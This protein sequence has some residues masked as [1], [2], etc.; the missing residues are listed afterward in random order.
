MNSQIESTETVEQQIARRAKEASIGGAR[1]FPIDVARN[2]IRRDAEATVETI[3]KYREGRESGQIDL[4]ITARP[5]KI[6]NKTTI[7]DG[8]AYYKVSFDDGTTQL[9]PAHRADDM[10]REI[11]FQA[12]SKHK[13]HDN[14]VS[15]WFWVIG[16]LLA[17][18]VFIFIMSNMTTGS[19]AKQG[20]TPSIPLVIFTIAAIIA[21]VIVKRR[22]K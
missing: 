10:K 22:D 13:E 9:C 19:A 16:G 3:R 6:S 20:D 21:F 4:Y 1:N 18:V 17:L 8:D 5:V 2:Q 15:A 14:S 12:Q 11:R 7:M